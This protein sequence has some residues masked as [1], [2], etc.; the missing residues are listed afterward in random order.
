MRGYTGQSVKRGYGD[1]ALRVLKA[2]CEVRTGKTQVL[3]M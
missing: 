2:W 3:Q 1:G